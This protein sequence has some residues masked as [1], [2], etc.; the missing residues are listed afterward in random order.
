MCKCAEA[1][2]LRDDKVFYFLEPLR[3]LKNI[4]SLDNVTITFRYN[5]YSGNSF[6]EINMQKLLSFGM[7]AY[8][9]TWIH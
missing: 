1:L 5:I 6:R 2:E 4:P 7:P 8:S 3:V 9:Y